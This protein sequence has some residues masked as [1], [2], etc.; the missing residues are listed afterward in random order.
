MTTQAYMKLF[1]NGSHPL[2]ERAKE[3]FTR[4]IS[5][6][7]EATQH[8][9]SEL[10]ANEL[11][12][13]SLGALVAL[14]SLKEY[15]RVLESTLG[16]HI[17]AIEAS[18]IC[19]QAT[20]YV[21]FARVSAFVERSF[22]LFEARGVAVP[23]QARTDSKTREQRG[24]EAQRAIFGEAIDR[25]NATAPSDEKHIR[26]YLSSNCFGDYYTREGLTLRFRELLTFVFLS[27][28]GGAQPQLIAHASG[29]LR[30]GNTRAKLIAAVT[31]LIP[32]MGYPRALNALSA[33]D[34]VSQ[35]GKG[36]ADK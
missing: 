18:E 28:L 6:S 3:Y 32:L 7:A 35:A 29:N 24:L 8:A 30:L 14:D 25:G 22:E 33:I 23:S 34:E 20:P 16:V 21:G 19:Y 1:Y 36:V 26:S 31:A 27:A 11:V 10:E 17:S 15:E 9:L 4:H 2:Q 12:K 13:L 5:F